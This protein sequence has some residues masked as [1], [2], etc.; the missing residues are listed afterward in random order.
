MLCINHRFLGL[1]CGLVGRVHGESHCNY[2]R[3]ELYLP[4]L[5]RVKMLKQYTQIVWGCGDGT[6][7]ASSIYQYMK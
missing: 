7:Q 6:L 5:G 1:N 2:S 3:L 4:R